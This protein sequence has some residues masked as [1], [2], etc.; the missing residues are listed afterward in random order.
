MYKAEALPSVLQNYSLPASPKGRELKAA[1]EASLGILDVVPDQIGISLLAAIYGAPILRPDYSIYIAGPTGAG[2]SEVAALAQQHYGAAMNARNLPCAWSSTANANELVSFYAKDAIIT[3]DDFCPTGSEFDIQ[4][5]HREADRILRAQGNKSGRSR[6]NASLTMAKTFTPRGLIISTGEDIPKGHSLRARLWILE[7][8]PNDLNFRKL[9]KAQQDAVSGRYAQAMAGYLQWI[10]PQYDNIQSSYRADIAKLREDALSS[11]SH[12]RT[13]DIAA[14]LGYA[15]AMFLKFAQHS[16]VIS[17]AIYTDLWNRCWQSLGQAAS[18][19]SILQSSGDPVERFLELVRAA[20]ES[21]SAH[22]A[23]MVGS[24]PDDPQTWG[25]KNANYGWQSCGT[26]MGWI[27]DEDVYLQPD[28]C[29]K[30]AQDMA[31]NSGEN[32]TIAAT[33][34]WKRLDERKVLK[35]KDE[36]RGR[37]TVRRTIAGNRRAVIHLAKL[38][39]WFTNAAQPSHEDESDLDPA[40]YEDD[41]WAMDRPIGPDNGISAAHIPAVASGPINSAPNQAV[42]SPIMSEKQSSNDSQIQ[43]RDGDPC[44]M[45]NGTRFWRSSNDGTWICERCHPCPDRKKMP[46]AVQPEM[47]CFLADESMFRSGKIVIPMSLIVQ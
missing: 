35:S 17:S 36:A 26:L 4:K 40:T 39:L 47:F 5:Q 28:A 42:T 43:W 25:W 21:Q 45:C 7:L 1:I 32:L 13:P 14:S 24:T 2:K 11:V 12:R 31:R 15:F 29:F 8:S 22:I 20:I 34:L 10:S 19:Q 6:M 18:R 30:V 44:R 9:S 41:L 38:T 46:D 37:F 33:T 27:D 23:S 16:G 3:I